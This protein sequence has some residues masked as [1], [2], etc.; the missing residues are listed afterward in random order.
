MLDGWLLFYGHESIASINM[1]ITTNHYVMLMMRVYT[2]ID[3]QR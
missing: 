1:T 3:A 2:V